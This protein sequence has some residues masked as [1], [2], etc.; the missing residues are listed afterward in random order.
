MRKH[1]S[2]KPLQQHRHLNYTDHVY[3]RKYGPTTPQ[4]QAKD[5]SSTRYFNP[6]WDELYVKRF[7]ITFKF[8]VC[9]L[10]MFVFIPFPAIFWTFCAA[11]FPR[12]IEFFRLCSNFFTWPRSI[13]KLQ[14]KHSLLISTW[15]RDLVPENLFLW[16]INLLCHKKFARELDR[17]WH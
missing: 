15:Q 8:S 13:H 12:S 4:V 17:T 11:R 14:N 5:D 2:R 3:W 7:Q 10:L 9:L 6:K 1:A 16:L